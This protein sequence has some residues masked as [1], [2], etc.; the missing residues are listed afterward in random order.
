MN[1]E[2]VREQHGFGASMAWYWG[3]PGT[4]RIIRHILVLQAWNVRFGPSSP[5]FTASTTPSSSPMLYG[6]P[7]RLGLLFALSS[8]RPHVR[9]I[10]GTT[11]NATTKLKESSLTTECDSLVRRGTQR[12]S[13]C[14]LLIC[15]RCNLALPLNSH[16][17]HEHISCSPKSKGFVVL[18]RCLAG[19]RIYF[20]P[21]P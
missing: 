13:M 18:K 9:R 17:S 1:V 10:L 16:S 12:Y 11:G 7:C 14:E 15:A 4:R 2:H 6:M 8:S 19:S 3:R 20:A 21:S 5:S